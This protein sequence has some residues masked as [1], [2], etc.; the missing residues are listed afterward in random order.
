MSAMLPIN[1]PLQGIKTA[2]D[3]PGMIFSRGSLL[4]YP[5]F[6][7]SVSS[8]AIVALQRDWKISDSG[9]RCG[10]CRPCGR[11]ER[12]HKGLGKRHKP[13]FSTSPT[14][15]ILLQE[16]KEQRRTLQVCPSKIVSTEGFTPEGCVRC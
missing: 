12:A 6:D 4:W 2:Q 13:P 15:I 9:R 11:T 7:S 10:R 14:P 3:A 5:L 1:R 16:E 8:K